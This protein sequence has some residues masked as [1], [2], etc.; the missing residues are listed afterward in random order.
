[1][2]EDSYDPEAAGDGPEPGPE[3]QDATRYPGHE[4]PDALRERAGL[5]EHDG[6]EPEV[7]PE[8]A[9]SDV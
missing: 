2:S 7:A 5:D 4:R 6:R 9:D 1:V 3:E 8:V